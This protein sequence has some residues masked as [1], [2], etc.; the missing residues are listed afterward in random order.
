M[1]NLYC[2]PLGGTVRDRF[3]RSLAEA[4]VAGR[5]R[6]EAYLLPSSY[7][8]NEVRQHMRDMGLSG[9]EQPNLLSFDELVDEILHLAGV[10]R[11]FMDRMTQEL[12][13]NKVLAEVRSSVGLP[14]FNSI[15]E[16]PGYV[17]AV[18]SLLAE[19]KRTGASPDEFAAAAAAREW[20]AKDQEVHVIY[21]AYQNSLAKLGLTDLEEKYYL[22]IQALDAGQAALPYRRLFIS[23]FYILTPL[24]VELVRRLNRTVTLEIGMIYEKN[25]PEMFAAVESTYSELVGMGFTPYFPAVSRTSA[26]GLDHARRFLFATDSVPIAADGAVEFVSSPSRE[27]EMTVIAAKIKNLLL[28]GAYRPEQVAVVVR[29]TGIY[30]DFRNIC[31]EFG[32]PVSLPREEQL[33]DQP[34]V[35]ML[36]NVC[37]ARMTNGARHAVINLMKSPFCPELAGF[38]ADDLEQR[39]LDHVVRTWDDW[40]SL[41]ERRPGGA[42]NSARRASFDKLRNLVGR[43]PKQGTCRRLTDAFKEF[44]VAIAVAKRL[45]EARRLGL[46]TQ[47]RLKAGLL[48][49][50]IIYDTLDEME[51]GFAMV[52]EEEKK[53]T[54]SEFLVYFHKALAGKTMILESYN[55]SGVQVVSPAGVRGTTFRAVF[56]LGL[57]EG[58]FPLR[59]RDNWLYNEGDR[60]LFGSLGLDLMNA[61][62]RRAEEDLYFAVAVA[63]ADDFLVLSGCEDAETMLSPYMEEIARLFIAGSVTWRKYGPGELFSTEYDALYSG[64]ELAG[65][66]LLDIFA[67][68]DCREEATTAA[69]YVLANILDSD[70]G[71]RAAGEQQRAGN[72]GAY[73]GILQA[74]ATVAACR[75]IT[76][77]SISALEDYARCPF[78]YFAKRILR[79]DDWEEKT[80]EAGHDLVG[81]VYHEVLSVFLRAHKGEIL[82]PDRIEDYLAQL[83][84][85]LEAVVGQLTKAKIII[86]GKLWDFQR[87]H[88]TRILRRWLEFEIKEQNGDGLVFTPAFLE[89]GFGLP[90]KEGM[91]E[92]SV[93]PPLALAMD[94][95]EVK[96]VGKVDRID[97]AGDYLTVVDY[98]RK[99]CPSFRDLA[100]GTD[101]QVAL[102]I[103]AAERLLCTEGNTMA[104]G[105]YY[106]IEGTRKEGGMWRAKLAE[107]IRHRAAKRAGNLTEQEWQALQAEVCRKIFGY[108]KGIQ[109]GKFPAAPSGDCPPYCVARTI[110][111]FQRRNGYIRRG[112]EGD[113]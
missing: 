109:A 92:A 43:L 74:P 21:C 62:R 12:L 97:K 82:R 61:V 67:S 69:T 63:L 77:F 20:P 64:R 66:A 3:V 15:A 38:D 31:G 55:A 70:F 94:N 44:V 93:T 102:Y 65:R 100:E 111:R 18:T 16:F 60:T 1:P 80:E 103:L 110:C 91:D 36:T 96:I 48:T 57:T 90:V 88:I 39:T 112:G 87:Q 68:G 35:R 4:V 78:L 14:Y 107:G 40:F 71:R 22:A 95:C 28:T 11:W 2:T 46:L 106:S 58:E 37:A 24:Q 7:L 53:L 89:W 105:G 47:E 72:F 13:V 59:D 101:L 9:Y 45:G 25:R 23:E 54:L 79:L 83:Q 85:E 10:R 32:I 108:V 42:E 56:V 33:K 30:K 19:I 73:G 113:A 6:E 50:Q 5:G 17:S 26:A 86:P 81:T 75:L 99:S 34:L 104:G 98:K 8:L 49:L 27:K 76:E 84:A 29:D 51:Q 52:G 41:F